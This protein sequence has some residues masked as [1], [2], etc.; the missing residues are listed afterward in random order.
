MNN[1]TKISILI[2]IIFF[3]TYMFNN[4]SQNIHI[5]IIQNT[6]KNYFIIKL[7]QNRSKLNSF[8]YILNIY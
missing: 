2:Q 5:Y 4:I 8:L 3:Y 7:Y 6:L 1:A